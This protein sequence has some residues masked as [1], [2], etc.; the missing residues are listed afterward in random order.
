[1]VQKIGFIGQHEIEDH[2]IA[3]D[4]FRQLYPG[5][6][7]HTRVSEN[8]KVMHCHM[9]GCDR[10]IAARLLEAL[11]VIRSNRLPLTAFTEPYGFIDNRH[12]LIISFD[13]TQ[14]RMPCY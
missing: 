11:N 12:V 9:R 5:L 4:A 1:M 6:T 8:G 14:A 7:L 13:P 10:Y 2:D 3:L